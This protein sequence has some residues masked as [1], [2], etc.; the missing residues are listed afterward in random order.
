MQQPTCDSATCDA[1]RPAADCR[2]EL[3]RRITGRDHR[4]F[5]RSLALLLGRRLRRL[6]LGVRFNFL[7][8]VGSTLRRLDF[9][10]FDLFG[11]LGGGSFLR[12]LDFRLRLLLDDIR[13]AA[14]AAAPLVAASPLAAARAALST[15]VAAACPRARPRWCRPPGLPAHD[16]CDGDEEQ[17]VRGAATVRT[18]ARTAQADASDAC[19]LRFCGFTSPAPTGRRAR[20]PPSA[21]QLITRT[22]VS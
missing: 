2:R 21:T 13:L 18:R 6:C 22:T 15:G 14:R 5:D 1:S 9:S 16:E 19:A 8:W 17:A 7:P 11:G 12:R 20:C 3:R 10:W 4:A